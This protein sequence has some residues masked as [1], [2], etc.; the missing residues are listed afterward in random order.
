MIFQC[1]REIEVTHGIYQAEQERQAA[2][3]R[4]EGEA[5]AAATISR[6]LDRA[7]EAFVAF[8]KIEASKAIAASLAG[9]RNVT[10]VPSGGSGLLLQL[11]SGR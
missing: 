2:V 8:R 7:G 4:A 5:E 11:P 6:A 3:I 10:Y 9:N 1:S